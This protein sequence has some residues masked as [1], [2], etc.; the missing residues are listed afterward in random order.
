MLSIVKNNDEHVFRLEWINIVSVIHRRK[1]H[2]VTVSADGRALAVNGTDGPTDNSM[3][4]A[5][6]YHTATILSDGQVVVADGFGAAA[7]NT[8]ELYDSYTI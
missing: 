8:A 7:G 4:V 2:I 3:I 1:Q 5:R 6:Y